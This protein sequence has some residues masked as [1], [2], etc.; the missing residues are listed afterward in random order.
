VS[1]AGR[2]R[3][4]PALEGTARLTAFAP[5]DDLNLAAAALL[6]DMVALQPS[7]RSAFGYK[8]A[9]KAIVNL[10]ESVVDLA[11]AD[12]LR[13]VPFVGPASTRIVRELVESGSSVT[14]EKA[15]AA[16]SKASDVAKRRALRANFLSEHAMRQVLAAAL[17]AASVSRESFRG[18]FQMHSTWSDGAESLPLMIEGCAALGQTC[19]GITDHSHGLP[20]AKGMSMETVARQ[21][22]E[23]DALNAGLAGRFRVFKGVEAN[24]QADGT[25]DLAPEERQHFEFVVAAPHA[26]LRRTE[27]QTARMLAAINEP[28][29]AMLGHPRGRV[30]DTRG[31]VQCDWPRIFAVAAER[32]IAVELDGNW[33]RQDLDFTLAAQ[34]LEAGCVF[35]LD[36]DAH[37]R[38]ELRFTDYAI[39][40]ARLAGIPS[41]RVINCWSDDRLAAWMAERQGRSPSRTAG[42]AKAARGRRA[43][44]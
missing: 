6:Y 25:L 1:G 12:R 18:D 28:G 44:R 23:I 32:G 36:S 41:E 8:R 15:I 31:G 13:D 37:S 7:E 39:A 33:H 29:I 14:V 2:D 43:V 22:Q 40:H 35:A 17:P 21:H 4:R 24:I 27:D 38:R 26:K 42:S 16:S 19:L 10:T 11:A 20:I 34:A 3:Q 30:F 9:A 5:P